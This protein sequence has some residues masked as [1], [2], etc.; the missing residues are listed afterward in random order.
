MIAIPSA[1][2][3]ARHG[4]TLRFDPEARAVLLQCGDTVMGNS[5]F[6]TN[7]IHRLRFV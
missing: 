1:S 5:A 7:G 6:H 2:T 3:K 4:D